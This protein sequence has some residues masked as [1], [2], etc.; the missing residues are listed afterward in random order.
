MGRI[1]MDFMVDAGGRRLQYQ[2][3]VVLEDSECPVGVA[4]RGAS[5][6]MDNVVVEERVTSEGGER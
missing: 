4:Y 6:D 1:K 3:T 2:G 5:Y